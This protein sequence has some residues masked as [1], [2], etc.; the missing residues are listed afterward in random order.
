MK[1]YLVM[2]LISG[3]VLITDAFKPIGVAFKAISLTGQHSGEEGKPGSLHKVLCHG[4]QWKT[5][6]AGRHRKIPVQSKPVL[7][8]SAGCRRNA[9][10]EKE[11][12][13]G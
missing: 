2:M 8:L 13:A 9:P 11:A 5:A 3:A 1:C 4:K 12:I 7:S 6:P 10:A